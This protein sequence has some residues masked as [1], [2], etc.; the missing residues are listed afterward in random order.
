MLKNLGHHYHIVTVT[1]EGR[2]I[3][4]TSRFD[5]VVH[6]RVSKGSAIDVP[7]YAISIQEML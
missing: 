1:V 3:K 4:T 2:F 7:D 5:C 6:F